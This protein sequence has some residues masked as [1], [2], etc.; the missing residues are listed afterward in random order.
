[1][2][3]TFGSDYID[4]RAGNDVIFGFAL[5]PTSNFS[6]VGIM[7]EADTIFGGAGN[8]LIRSGGGADFVDGGRGNDTIIGGN[9]ADLLLGGAG[10]DVFK[11]EVVSLQ[12]ASSP[13]SPLSTRWSVRANATCSSTSSR[14]GTRST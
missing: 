3:G 10:R 11:F 4:G 12:G 5:V 7:D 2:E 9:G 8:D 1:L 14:A 6:A 13:L